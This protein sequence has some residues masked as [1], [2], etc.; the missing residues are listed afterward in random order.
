[1][2]SF[3]KILVILL[4]IDMIYL[5]LSKDFFNSQVRLIQGSDIKLNYLSALICYLFI[6][7][8]FYKFLYLSKKSTYLDCFLLGFLTYGIF[9][10]TNKAIFKKWAWNTVLLDTTWGGILF[11]LLKFFVDKIK[12]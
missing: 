11:M 9:D 7:I 6:A 3:F 10:L 4:F 1:M 2:K 5:Y 8:L 12:I